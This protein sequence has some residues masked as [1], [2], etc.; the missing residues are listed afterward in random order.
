MDNIWYSAKR[1]ITGLLVCAMVAASIPATA[2][3][4]RMP[5]GRSSNE[6]PEGSVPVEE[7]EVTDDALGEAT[8]YEVS[9]NYMLKYWNDLY[10]L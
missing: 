4:A 9:F 1:W 3:A 6:A 10:S 5:E 7:A 2:Y 8:K